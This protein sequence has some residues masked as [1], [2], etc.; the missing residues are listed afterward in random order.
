MPNIITNLPDSF[1]KTIMKG[2]EGDLS[3]QVKEARKKQFVPEED[4]IY[5][6][7]EPDKITIKELDDEDKLI[8]NNFKK[9]IDSDDR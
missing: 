5:Y 3:K 9:Y 6:M 7:L 4:E 2:I 1:K 8:V